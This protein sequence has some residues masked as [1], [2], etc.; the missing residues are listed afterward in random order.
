V[1][2]VLCFISGEWPL[3]WAPD[4]FAGVRVEGTRSIRKLVA[5]PTVLDAPSIERV[6]R[7]LA[8]SL[9]AK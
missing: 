5:A 2:P 9:P 3:F 6:A 8:A 4:E 1:T 7:V